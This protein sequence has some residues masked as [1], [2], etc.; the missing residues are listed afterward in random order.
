MV[1]TFSWAKLNVDTVTLQYK[2]NIMPVSIQTA[3]EVIDK[4][5]YI[6]SL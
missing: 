6:K 5:N 4:R 3:K 1:I 2:K